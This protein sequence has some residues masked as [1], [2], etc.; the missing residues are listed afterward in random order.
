[1]VTNKSLNLSYHALAINARSQ[2]AYNGLVIYINNSTKSRWCVG[3]KKE[4]RDDLHPI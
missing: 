3:D 1:M 2:A 4:E